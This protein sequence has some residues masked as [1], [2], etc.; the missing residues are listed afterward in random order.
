MNQMLS[1]TALTSLLKDKFDKVVEDHLHLLDFPHLPDDLLVGAPAIAAST[2]GPGEER[3]VYHIWKT[4]PATLALM[5]HGSQIA[6]QRSVIKATFWAR[7][8]PG[9]AH[10]NQELLV[11]LHVLLTQILFLTARG[12]NMPAAI[13]ED[14]QVRALTIEALRMIVMLIQ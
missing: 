13:G 10:E 6:A 12:A 4:R 9:F 14:A 3:K 5:P 8:R 11:R 7:V 1:T 2:Y